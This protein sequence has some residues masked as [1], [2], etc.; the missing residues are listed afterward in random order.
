[1][2]RGWAADARDPLTYNLQHNISEEMEEQLTEAADT[3]ERK[4][5]SALHRY[6][7]NVLRCL[8]VRTLGGDVAD[9][10]SLSK[11]EL[12]EKLNR[13]VSIYEV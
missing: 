1:M 13:Y 8:C 4:A 10:R 12:M 11:G 5:T 7:R 3:L 2:E 6:K 9:Y